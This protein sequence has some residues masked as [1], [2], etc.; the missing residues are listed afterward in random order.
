MSR[1]DPSW[2]VSSVPARLRPH[3]NLFA[4]RAAVVVAFLILGAQLFR[5]QIVDGEEYARRSRENHMT[6]TTTLAPRGLIVDRNGVA[7]VRNKSVYVATILPELLPEAEDRRYAIYLR[8]EELTGIP[9]LAIQSD[10]KDREARNQAFIEIELKKQLTKEQALRLAEAVVDMPGVGM[11]VRP[12]REYIAGPAFSHILGYVGKLSAEEYAALSDEDYAFDEITGKAGIESRYERDLRGKR[13]LTS[14]EQDAEGRLIEAFDSTDAVPGNSVKLALDAGLQEY[15][16][17][18]LSDSLAVLGN[19]SLN[20]DAHVA[21]AVVMDAR[22][23][24]VLAIVSVPSYDNNIWSAGAARDAE[25][26]GLLSDELASPLLNKAVSN[27]APGSTFKLVT[28]AAALETGRI[29]P[30]TTRN[31]TS[32]T[33]E[34]KGEDDLPFYLYD[35]REHGSVNLYDAI[36]WSSNIYFFQASCGILGESRG[37]GKNTYDSA[38]I[39]AYYARQFGFDS[40]TGIDIGGEESGLIPDPSWK[41]RIHKDDN[42]EDQDWYY[43]DT[44]NMA[45]GQGDVTAT[46]LQIARMTAAVA[47][48]GKL[49]TPHVAAAIID[50]SGKTVREIQPEWNQVPVTPKYLADIRQGMHQSVAGGAAGALAAVPGIDIAGKTGTAEFVD[51]KSGKIYEHAWFTGFAPF[52][53]PE[54]VVTVYFDR[55]VGGSKAAPVAGKILQYYWENVR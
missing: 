8:L 55:G 6:V 21:A 53:D 51:T 28:A 30:A 16:S 19:D 5:M 11:A 9:A 39:L 38:T 2:R 15:V 29:T 23:G 20:G 10:V 1:N 27:A 14:A 35:W 3:G 33:L 31:V 13:G 42:P 32:R 43:G 26:Q 24:Q 18:L 45:I 37:L 34:L 41:A 17:E 44:C 52:D 47:N 22:T 7:L 4:L 25:L 12:G 36:A 50:A 40:P 49:L 54:I 48:G 46:P